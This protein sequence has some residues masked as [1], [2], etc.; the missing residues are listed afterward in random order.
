MQDGGRVRPCR[1]EFGTRVAVDERASIAGDPAAQSLTASQHELT[2]HLG[3]G[4]GGESA[5]QAVGGVRIQEQ[6][7]GGKNTK[8]AKDKAQ[9][10]ALT[11][12]CQSLIA[13]AEFRYLN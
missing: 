9:I 5:A 1:V 11:A 4:A 8:E 3:V 7:A 6:A 13:S 10:A 2:K 12:F